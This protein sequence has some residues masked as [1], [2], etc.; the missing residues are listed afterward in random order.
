M[1]WARMASLVSFKGVYAMVD[2]PA[3]SSVPG[4]YCPVQGKW[5]RVRVGGRLQWVRLDYT[6]CLQFADELSAAQVRDTL[7]PVQIT[8]GAAV[9][10]GK[11]TGRKCEFAQVSISGQVLENGRYQVLMGEIRQYSW[12]AVTRIV[13]SGRPF[14]FD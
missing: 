6:N 14:M 2:Y 7:P 9:Y 4:D 8:R 10:D 3:M 11:I 12:A 5:E 1:T 13:N